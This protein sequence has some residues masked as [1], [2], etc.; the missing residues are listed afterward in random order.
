[1]SANIQYKYHGYLLSC[2]D[3]I[4]RASK[5]ELSIKPCAAERNNCWP[6]AIL[7]AAQHIV[8]LAHLFYT[9]AYMVL[10]SGNE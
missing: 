5:A 6:A 7:D 8:E 9:H 3:I 4:Y 2:S 1:M 10:V